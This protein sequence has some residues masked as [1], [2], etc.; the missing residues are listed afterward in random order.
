[1]ADRTAELDLLLK[2]KDLGAGAVKT[3]SDGLDTVAKA[4]GRARDSLEGMGRS[5]SVGLGMV[6]ET[7]LQGGGVGQAAVQLG[8]FMASELTETFGEQAIAK[9]TGSSLMAAITAPLGAVGSAMGGIMAAAIPVGMAL[10]PVIIAGAIIAAIAVLIFNED[11]RNKVFGFIGGVLKWMG[12]AL[13]KLGDVFLKA[14]GAVWGFI[15]KTVPELGGKIVGGI[16]DAFVSFPGKVAQVIGDAFRNLKIDIGPFHI[17][18][19]GIT[20][21]LPK[22]SAQD[23]INYHTSGV[24]PG[25]A[26]GGWVGLHG[27][28]IIATGEKGPEYVVSN[29]NLGMMGR[30]ITIVLSIGDQVIRKTIAPIVSGELF[31][32]LDASSATGARI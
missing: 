22:I 24:V 7:L 17:T 9:L 23:N 12:D 30:P 15:S 4:G 16:I 8:I 3:F 13:G 1:M 6:T 10:L 31:Y 14:I 25:K 2:A 27:P 28:E 18:G 32:E 21:D 19:S 5:A 29:D 20:I 26:S 11:I